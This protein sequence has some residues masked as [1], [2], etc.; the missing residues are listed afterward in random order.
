MIESNKQKCND[1]CGFL[2][3]VILSGTAIVIACPRYQKP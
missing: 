2:K 1:D 3:F